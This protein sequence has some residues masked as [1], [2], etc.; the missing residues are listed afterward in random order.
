MTRQAVRPRLSRGALGPRGVQNVL[1][2]RVMEPDYYEVLQISPDA[3]FDQV[4][5]AY[6]A[7][8]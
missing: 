7:L 4:H 6:R 2:R 8:A 5:K 3:T 1:W